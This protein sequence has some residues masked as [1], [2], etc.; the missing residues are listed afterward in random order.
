MPITISP[1]SVA[2]PE[3]PYDK[4]LVYLNISPIVQGAEIE[5]AMNLR[6]VPYRIL[7]DGMVDVAEAMA[8][9]ESVGQAFA[10]SATDPAL[11]AAAG[12][13]FSAIQAFLTARG[14]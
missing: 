13:I 11:A 1:K 12:V 5:A 8:Y 9:N 2:F 10:Q 4:S 3:I 6:V 7:P 14:V